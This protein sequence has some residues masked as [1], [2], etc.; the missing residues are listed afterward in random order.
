[1]TCKKCGRQNPDDARFCQGC[2]NNL[3]AQR[4]PVAE[5]TKPATQAEEAPVVMPQPAPRPVP[6]SPASVPQTGTKVA[7]V[8]V[9]IV[10]IILLLV[11]F[12]AFG[13]YPDEV[14]ACIQRGGSGQ[15]CPGAHFPAQVFWLLGVL[16]M[17]YGGRLWV[18]KKPG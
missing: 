14:R 10:S 12:F 2:G 6:P 7:A 11:G 5:S 18:R 16:G 15:G 9:W 8:C 3:A 17:G 4:V 1:M 13:P